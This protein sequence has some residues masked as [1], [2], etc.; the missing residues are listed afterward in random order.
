MGRGMGKGSSYVADRQFGFHVDT[1]QLEWGPFHKLLLY[2]GYVLLIGL[3]SLASIGEEACSLTE[4]RSSRMG[5]YP[6]E[7]SPGEE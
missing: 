5:E 3:P 7:P 6:G 4:T 1:K 2:V